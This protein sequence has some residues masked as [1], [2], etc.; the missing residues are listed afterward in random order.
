MNL[1]PGSGDC[2]MAA[3]RAFPM[4]MS[5]SV[6]RWQPRLLEEGLQLAPERKLPKECEWKQGESARGKKNLF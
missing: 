2:D 1:S 5:S 4:G 6:L 3:E